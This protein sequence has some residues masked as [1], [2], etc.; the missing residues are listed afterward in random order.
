MRLSFIIKLF[1]ESRI[2]KKKFTSK[3]LKYRIKYHLIWFQQT[4]GLDHQLIHL[5][6][7]SMASANIID[8]KKGGI[9]RLKVQQSKIS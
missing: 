7:V 8:I 1:F 2:V 5:E 9:Q 3:D 6:G 4:H